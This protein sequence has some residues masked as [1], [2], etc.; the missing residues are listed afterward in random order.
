VVNGKAKQEN[1]RKGKRQ[2]EKKEEPETAARS[3][4]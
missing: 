1:E 4:V 3:C 2:S